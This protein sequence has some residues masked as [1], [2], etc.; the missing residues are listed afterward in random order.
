MEQ[1]EVKEEK[2]KSSLGTIIIIIIL[3]LIILFAVWYF[4]LRDKGENNNGNNNPQE[5]SENKGSDETNATDGVLVQMN[6]NQNEFVIDGVILV[7]NRHGYLD[8][9]E[10][11][12]E[13]IAKLVKQ[14]YKKTGINSSFYLNEHIEIY[15]DTKYSGSTDNVKVYIIPHKTKTEYETITAAEIFDIANEKG[16]VIIYKKPDEVNYKYIGDPYVSMDYPAGKYDLVFL[17]NDK[18][19]YYVTLDLTKEPTE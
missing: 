17:Y 9:E 15:V 5:Q 19:A 3:L 10:G 18:V 1:E 4:L 13:I 7:G 2:K 11:S 12:E 14:G 6:P 16:E 8:L